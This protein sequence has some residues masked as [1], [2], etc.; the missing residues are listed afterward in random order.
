MNDPATNELLDKLATVVQEHNNP[1]P[2]QLTRAEQA[3][4][5]SQQTTSELPTQAGP[6][7]IRFDFN[8]GCRIYLPT[9]AEGFYRV[10]I[11]DLD[12]GNTLIDTG[13]YKGGWVRSSRLYYSRFCIE[14]KVGEE[15]SS[16]G[17]TL[18]LRHDYDPTGRDILINLPPGTLG[19]SIGWFS[20]VPQWLVEHPGSKLTCR[21]QRRMIPLFS[22]GYPDITFLPCEESL[23]A[24][25]GYYATYHLGLFYKDTEHVCAPCDHRLVGLHR[26]AAYIL[27]LDPLEHRPRIQP[28][29]KGRPI[30][31]PYVCIATQATT[32]PKYWNNPTGW[33]ELIAWLKEQG[34]RVICIDAVKA[35]GD[36]THYNTIPWGCEDQT[37]DRPLIE[38]VRWLRHAE[39]F[40]GLS[41]GLSWLAWAAGCPVVLIS[42]FTH[43][44]NEFYTPH[45][46]INYHTCN[47]CW[48]DSRHDFD[49]NDFLW[50]PRHA[51]TSRQFECTRLI[52]TDLVKR[53]IQPLL[54]H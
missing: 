48:N 21:I 18:I 35:H 36:G 42:G 40:V 49:N 5:T 34:Y 11:R 13:D 9:L 15:G 33:I 7:G 29:F 52:T 50:C 31:Q 26:T 51:G 8:E 39:F 6:L 41:S 16:D 28:D 17:K 32:Q 45:R 37:G 27:G 1:A 46:V 47:S 10:R 38:R 24:S 43:P 20:Y 22:P 44:I 3:A 12:T 4:K 30:E 2:R 54:K 19:D 53:V 14:I 23:D 25:K